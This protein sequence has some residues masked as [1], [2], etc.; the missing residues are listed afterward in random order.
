VFVDLSREMIKRS[1]EYEEGSSLTRRYEAKLHE[2]Y[3]RRGY[4]DEIPASAYENK[5]IV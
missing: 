5:T 2:H 1:P 4:W 3:G